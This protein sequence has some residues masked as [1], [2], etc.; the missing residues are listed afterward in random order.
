MEPGSLGV[1]FVPSVHIGTVLS[2]LPVHPNN[3]SHSGSRTLENTCDFGQVHHLLD[4][5]SQKTVTLQP[6]PPQTQTTFF[7]QIS[8]QNSIIM[9]HS[10]HKT[11]HRFSRSF[12]LYSQQHKSHDVVL[13][14]AEHL[15]LFSVCIE[16]RTTRP[17]LGTPLHPVA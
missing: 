13:S 16:R 6:G 10:G 3:N 4:R 15:A 7:F 9:L 12:P 14:T 5:K 11:Q 8:D 2:Y 1:N 17:C